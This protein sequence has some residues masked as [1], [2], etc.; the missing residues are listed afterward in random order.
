MKEI[1]GTGR[2]AKGGGL[3]RAKHQKS[4]QTGLLRDFDS[5]SRRFDVWPIHDWPVTCFV[6][7]RG[8]CSSI[9]GPSRSCMFD[10]E[11]QQ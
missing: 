2:P 1:A 11:D 8:S 4:P 5:E 6:S 7:E 9:D 3:L 10:Q